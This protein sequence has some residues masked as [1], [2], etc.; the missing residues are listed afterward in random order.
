MVDNFKF[1]ESLSVLVRRFDRRY[2]AEHMLGSQISTRFVFDMKCVRH[3]LNSAGTQFHNGLS[4]STFFS[5][6]QFVQFYFFFYH[7]NVFYVEIIA[8]PVNFLN[9]TWQTTFVHVI[10]ECRT[11]SHPKSHN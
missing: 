9:E 10:Y 2:R 1:P 6:I 11:E 5:I 7:T 4:N 8:K 3:S